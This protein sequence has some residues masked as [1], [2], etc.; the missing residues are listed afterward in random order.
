MRPASLLLS[1]SVQFILSEAEGSHFSSFC[2]L[3]SLW[4]HLPSPSPK[5]RERCSIS[6]IIYI[7]TTSA[8]SLYSAFFGD[9]EYSRKAR[10]VCWWP[11]LKGKVGM[12]PY[13]ASDCSI[14][15]VSELI[16]LLVSTFLLINLTTNTITPTANTHPPR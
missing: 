2:L 12:G 3:F 16:N 15:S 14:P 1:S 13:A 7:T 6:L 11:S 8:L 9:T 4:P 5:E 10:A